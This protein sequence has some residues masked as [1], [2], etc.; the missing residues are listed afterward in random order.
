MDV[1]DRLDETGDPFIRMGGEEQGSS[2]AS[3][4]ASFRQARMRVWPGQPAD[5]EVRDD[6]VWRGI[7]QGAQDL[8]KTCGFKFLDLVLMACECSGDESPCSGAVIND[9]NVRHGGFARS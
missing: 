3:R 1:A 7:V 6:Q 4:R 5:H 2:G 8:E 9:G